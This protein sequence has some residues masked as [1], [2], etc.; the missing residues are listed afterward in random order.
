LAPDRN[1]DDARQSS[2][3]SSL[4]MVAI[5]IPF[6]IPGWP[7]SLPKHLGEA[8]AQVEQVVSGAPKPMQAVP[9]HADPLSLGSVGQVQRKA[10]QPQVMVED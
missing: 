10:H 2:R 6:R 3:T 1:A 4:L 9:L 5:R 7:P 8:V